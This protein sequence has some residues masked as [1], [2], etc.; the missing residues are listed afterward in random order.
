MVRDELEPVARH[1]DA[2]RPDVDV[3]DGA[4]GPQL[5]AGLARH[6]L[7]LARHRAHAPDGHAPLAGAVAEAMEEE[8]AVL[9]ERRVVQRR[10]RAD[11]AVGADD[12]AH[13]VVAEAAL[14]RDTQ[15]L[16]DDVGP[17][18]H[19]DLV[20]Q[21]TDVG[22]WLQ[23]GRGHGPGQPVDVGVERLPGLE[24]V[25]GAGQLAE[26][27]TGRLALVGLDQQAPLVVGRVRRRGPRAQLEPEPEVLDQ[28]IGH[29]ADEVGEARQPGVEVVERPHAHRRAADVVEPFEHHDVESGPGQIGR[30]DE[31]VVPAPDDHDVV[32][33]GHEPRRPDVR[34][35]RPARPAARS[36]PARRRRTPRV[37]RG[38]ARRC[39]TPARRP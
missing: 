24:L 29:Q 1:G 11:Q 22:E 2:V 6:P 35:R 12:P 28:R 13:E 25:V 19:V 37:S 4:A 39:R 27:R 20:A 31:G 3:L 34:P 18:D 26:R 33:S 15:R 9:R 32:I 16:L 8:A 38:W 14:E 30:G 23:Q 36:P 7:Q 10:E 21:V 5:G 17:G